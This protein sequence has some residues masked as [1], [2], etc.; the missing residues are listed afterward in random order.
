MVGSAD[1]GDIEDGTM[2]VRL[3]TGVCVKR[4]FDAGGKPFPGG[5]PSGRIAVTSAMQ[6]LV[7][8]GSRW[9]ET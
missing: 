2:N 3:R 1:A 5:T 4:G 8:P 6:R 9:P 7:R